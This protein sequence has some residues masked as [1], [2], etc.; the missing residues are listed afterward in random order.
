[1]LNLHMQTLK[2]SCGVCSII[3][4]HKAQSIG[5]DPGIL[6]TLEVRRA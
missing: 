5:G 6:F 4:H 3:L 2:R 1:M